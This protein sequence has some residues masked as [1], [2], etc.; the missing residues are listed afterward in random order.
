MKSLSRVFVIIFFLTACTKNTERAKNVPLTDSKVVPQNNEKSFDYKPELPVKGKLFAAIEI[1]SAG[2]NYFIVNMDKENRWTLVESGFGESELIENTTEIETI[3]F[4]IESYK[5]AILRSGVRKKDIYVIASS[6]AIEL[7]K[8]E[9]IRSRLEL[10]GIKLRTV[11]AEQEGYFDL[12]ATVPVEFVEES[13]LI[14]I[15]SGSTKVTWITELDTFS[16]ET[17]G[18]KYYM[19]D[20]HDTTTF[21]I[22]RDQLLQ[23]PL[24]NR[25][26]CFMLGGIPYEFAAVTGKKVGRYTILQQPGKYSP[27]SQKGKAGKIL[28]SA[29]YLEPTYSYIFDWDANFSIGY[30]MSM[31]NDR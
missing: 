4:K 10:S 12:L 6:S 22:V 18:S 14:D 29:F 31:G 7:S 8:M 17:F 9:D 3:F 16:I 26:L 30:L 1:G 28:Y 15:G 11:N 20:I 13:F 21:R 24:K 23:I 27:S 5:R 2:L 25:N 19:N